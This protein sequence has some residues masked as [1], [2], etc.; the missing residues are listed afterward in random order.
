MARATTRRTTTYDAI[1]RLSLAK[2]GPTAGSNA[3]WSRGFGYDNFGNMWVTSPTGVP[4]NSFTP[5][6][7][8]WYSNLNRLVNAGLGIG[9]DNAGNQTSIGAY[10]QSYDA[11][12]RLASSTINQTTTTYVYDG[13]GRRVKKVQGSAE[14][15][16]VYDAAGNLAV[17][18]GPP[19][20]YPCTT[21]YL[22]ADHLGSTRM[23]TDAGGAVKALHD[24]LPFGEEVPAGVPAGIGGRSSD[25]YPAST[26]A[27]NDTINQK[28][29]CKERD[30]ETARRGGSR[31][32]MRHSRIKIR[33]TRR[34]G[35]FMAIK[36]QATP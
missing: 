14:T 21:C 26:L 4:V 28:F 34:V 3:N 32:R 36:E 11:E 6:G 8:G 17:E 7:Q 23:V 33:P 35:I 24:F 2:E 10:A 13:E 5:A 22:T 31:V 15:V 9:Y 29:T 20:N 25:Y 12:N 19:P 18:Y 27:I 1:N 30:T 16:Y